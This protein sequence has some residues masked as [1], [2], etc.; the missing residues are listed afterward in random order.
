M[1]ERPRFFDDLAGVA[2][3]AFSAFVGLR[4][5]AEAMMRARCDEAI[6]KFDLVKREDLDAVQE[7][8]ANAR[9]GQEAAEARVAA[10]EQRIAAL[11]MSLSGQAPASSQAS[12]SSPAD[13]AESGMGGARGGVPGE[14]GPSAPT[15]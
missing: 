6:R 12:A 10:L 15:S 2:G 9:S 3:G 13:A 11:E 8:A 14:P 4:D 1:N 7:M 5:E